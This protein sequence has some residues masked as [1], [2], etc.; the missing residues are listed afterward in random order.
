MD[1]PTSDDI[2]SVVSV[3]KVDSSPV[4][5]PTVV[6]VEK[7]D[8]SALV[9][10]PTVI[11]RGILEGFTGF[12]CPTMSFVRKDTPPSVDSAGVVSVGKAPTVLVVPTVVSMGTEDTVEVVPSVVSMG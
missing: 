5:D 8:A 12:G 7:V 2:S 11:S 3:G 6:C 9:E 10:V 1:V 4:V